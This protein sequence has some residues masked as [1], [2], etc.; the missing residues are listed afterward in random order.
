MRPYLLIAI[1]GLCANGCASPHPALV[2]IW[3]DGCEKIS[4]NSSINKRVD[5]VDG[6]Y[7]SGTSQS[8]SY[9][10]DR[11]KYSSWGGAKTFNINEYLTGIQDIDG[12]NLLDDYKHIEYSFDKEQV[13]VSYPRKKIEAGKYRAEKHEW[14]SS[15]CEDYREFWQ[16]K[17]RNSPTKKVPKYC[18]A[19]V[20][21]NDISARYMVE[22]ELKNISYPSPNNERPGIKIAKY[23][24]RITDRSENRLL[25][26]SEWHVM[27]WQEPDV[28]VLLGGGG[29]ISS[30]KCGNYLRIQDVL[31]P[32]P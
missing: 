2:D 28:L 21:L 20:S 6:F 13:Y 10:R 9:S 16:T 27:E 1:A 15:N 7:W 8:L 26:S 11:S 4:G 5:I 3:H 29:K 30:S 31:T 23:V 25:A 32:R 17:F 12:K 14:D 19:I 24:R 22:D 18:I